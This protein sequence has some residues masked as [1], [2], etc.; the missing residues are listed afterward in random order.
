MSREFGDPVDYVGRIFDLLAFR[1]AER[2]GNQLL[3]QTI[4]GADA[5]GEVCTGVQ[6]LA[7]RWVLKFLTIEGSMTYLPDEGT[8]FIASVRRGELRTEADV[9][10]AFNIAAVKVRTDL[11]NEETDDMN[12][13]ERMGNAE[14]LEIA[15]FDD[16]FSLQVEITSLAGT[17]RKVILPIPYLPIK[18]G[19]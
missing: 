12:D 11:I 17:S 13:E 1:G 7:Q 5:S 4:F 18:V 2:V 6:M 19:P 15:I 3:D 8:D 9:E 14:L 16:M 10:G